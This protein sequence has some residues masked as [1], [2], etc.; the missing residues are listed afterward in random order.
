MGTEKKSGKKVE[1][2][3]AG[4]LHAK[5]M[6]KCEKNGTSAAQVIRDLIQKYVKD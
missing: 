2:K 3:L 4:S 6:R 1:S 5:F